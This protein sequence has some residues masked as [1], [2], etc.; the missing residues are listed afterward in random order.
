M[1]NIPNGP[2]LETYIETRLNLITEAAHAH[3]L[4][5]RENLAAAVKTLEA[6]LAERDI[7]YQQRF[8]A[9]EQAFRITVETAEKAVMAALAAQERAVNKAEAASE[10]RFEG[11]NEF[12]NTLADQQ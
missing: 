6:T 5:I 9:Q 12:R 8:E 1:P 3:T 10:K 4:V 7:R 11:V 2:S